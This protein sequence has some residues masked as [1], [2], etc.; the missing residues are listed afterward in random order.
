MKIYSELHFTWYLTGFLLF[1]CDYTDENEEDAKTQH[2]ITQT[3]GMI[4]AETTDEKDYRGSY[5]IFY[6]GKC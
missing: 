2:N 1:S 4:S 6:L 5:V 3:F